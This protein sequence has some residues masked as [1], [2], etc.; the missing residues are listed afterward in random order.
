ERQVHERVQGEI[1]T[2][3][4]RL[5]LIRVRRNDGARGGLEGQRGQDRR[6]ESQRCHPRR[7]DRRRNHRQHRV[8][9]QGRP[10]GTPVPR[11]ARGGEPSAVPA[12]R[13]PQERYLGG[14]LL[15]IQTR[16]KGGAARRAPPFFF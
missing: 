10:P 9:R 8:R 15:E 2:G 14:V 4:R 5:L 11:R 1:R 12:D 13:N 7:L 3:S 6:Q 16:T